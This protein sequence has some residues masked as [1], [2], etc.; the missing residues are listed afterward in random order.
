MTILGPKEENIHSR[1]YR[2]ENI[3]SR[4]YRAEN[5]NLAGQNMEIFRPIGHK[6]DSTEIH[7]RPGHLGKNEKNAIRDPN[8]KGD[9]KTLESLC[10]TEGF[11]A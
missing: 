2:A 11:L 10:K 7:F 3:H 4:P 5:D 1:P 9:S 8:S 6:I